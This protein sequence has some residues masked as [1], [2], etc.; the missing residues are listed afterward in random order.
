MYSFAYSLPG[1]FHS[2][3][4]SF[5]PCNNNSLI[6]LLTNENLWFFYVGCFFPFL[7]FCS[8]LWIAATNGIELRIL[9]V[10]IYLTILPTT[11]F[12]AQ[13]S[14]HFSFVAFSIK[15]QN[16]LHVIEFLPQNTFKMRCL[17]NFLSVCKRVWRIIKAEQMLTWNETK[18]SQLKTIRTFNHIKRITKVMRMWSSSFILFFCLILKCIYSEGF[19]SLSLHFLQWQRKKKYTLNSERWVVVKGETIVFCNCAAIRRHPSHI[20]YA[21]DVRTFA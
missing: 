12:H 11:D 2:N 18:K 13:H 10:I 17:S 4:P 9:K 19:A 21:L 15:K 7:L 1:R 14:S 3:E 16:L 8:V 20:Y 6:F 5:L